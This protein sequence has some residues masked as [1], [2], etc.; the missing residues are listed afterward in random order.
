MN[1]ALP[2]GFVV[3][4]GRKPGRLPLEPHCV[5]ISARGHVDAATLARA[6]AHGRAQGHMA[7]LSVN[8]MIGLWARAWNGLQRAQQQQR[9]RRGL[10]LGL[11]LQGDI[12]WNFVY[13]RRLLRVVRNVC[14]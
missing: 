3:L 13:A 8:A 6:G 2:V 7:K 14:L 1:G 12:V 10:L 4:A 5:G 11:R 9:G